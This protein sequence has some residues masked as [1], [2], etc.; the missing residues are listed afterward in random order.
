MTRSIRLAA[1]ALATSFAAAPAIA[2]PGHGGWF[3]G[4]AHPFTGADHLAAML[5]V[6]L[7]SATRG[8]GR[9]WQGPAAFL[10]A[11]LLGALAGMAGGELPLVEAGTVASL[12][13]F[14][15]MLL[16]GP[17]L[18]DGAG[19][20]LIGAAGLVH[21]YAHGTEVSGSVPAFVAGFVLSS[22]V[23]H[24]GGFFAGRRLLTLRNGIAAAAGLLIA[25]SAALAFS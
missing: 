22:A 2:H 23:L 7:W 11:L 16:A 25:G 6:G 5:A 8:P 14:G 24:A 21:G 1:A 20:T 18:G 4:L 10:A 3:D 15:A 19:L 17:R 9:A 13:L 12:A